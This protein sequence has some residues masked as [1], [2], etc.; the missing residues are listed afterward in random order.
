[1][2]TQFKS[3]TLQNQMSRE[4]FP[5]CNMKSSEATRKIAST[6]Y[7]QFNPYSGSISH[8]PG[9]YTTQKTA[10]SSAV[11]LSQFSPS[12]HDMFRNIYATF[13]SNPMSIIVALQFIGM[14]SLDS[15]F[16]SMIIQSTIFKQS[17]EEG[18]QPVPHSPAACPSSLNCVYSQ[19]NTL[20]IKLSIQ[21]HFPWPFMHF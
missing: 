15:N 2:K 8:F 12:L 1:M 6:Q 7:V 18:L 13:L 20:I 10:G 3:K 14:R 21:L 11:H 19:I 5:P 16:T 17:L 9:D 4:S